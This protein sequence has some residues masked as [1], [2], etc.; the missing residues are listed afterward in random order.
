MKSYSQFLRL[1]PSRGFTLVELLVVIAVLGVLATVVLV[2]VNPAEQLARGRDSHRISAV[3]QLGRSEQ[4]YYTVVGNYHLSGGQ[5]GGYDGNWQKFLIDSSDIK[6][7][8]SNPSYSNNP[9]PLQTCNSSIT[10]STGV[11]NG[12][13]GYCYRNDGASILSQSIVFVQLESNLYTK[14]C[15][16][17]CGGGGPRAWAVWFSPQGKTGLWCSPSSAISCTP[18]LN[19]GASQVTSV[20]DF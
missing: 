3:T 17:N 4:N 16:S 20:T 9:P 10:Q 8:I 14:R 11:T 6:L 13:Y 18:I 19:S 7:P 12:A 1:I 5:P 2:A 15:S